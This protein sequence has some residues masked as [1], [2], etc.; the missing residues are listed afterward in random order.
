MLVPTALSSNP[1]FVNELDSV[2]SSC[3]TLEP[4]SQ[5]YHCTCSK[6]GSCS[7]ERWQSTMPSFLY[8]DAYCSTKKIVAVVIHFT[9]ALC[10]FATLYTVYVA[11]SVVTIDDMLWFH[12]LPDLTLSFR[13][14]FF[15][16][17][18]GAMTKRYTRVA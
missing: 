1:V 13:V 15:H 7:E 5:Y 17:C 16:E 10:N 18:R 12:S 9:R 8:L 11:F 6:S 2:S 14:V 4:N 3:F